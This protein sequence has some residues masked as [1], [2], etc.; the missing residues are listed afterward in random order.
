[1]QNGRITLRDPREDRDFELEVC[2]QGPL[3]LWGTIRATLE[4]GDGIDRPVALVLWLGPTRALNPDAIYASLHSLLT[5]LARA[6]SDEA[7]AELQPEFTS[8]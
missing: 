1:M 6:V 7:E 8:H 4:T 3:G 2:D 5:S